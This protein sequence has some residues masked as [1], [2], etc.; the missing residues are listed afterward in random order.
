MSA[1]RIP[2]QEKL[3]EQCRA[4]QCPPPIY[5]EYSDRRGGRTAWSCSVHI[6]PHI[7]AKAT[8][9]YDG[10]YVEKAKDD[11]ALN[12]LQ[13]L[14][15]GAPQS[16]ALQGVFQQQKHQQAIQADPW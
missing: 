1:Q 9:W 11:A 4:L 8:Y 10:K 16:H 12:M 5:K 2:W 6:G 13:Q 15:K 3:Q 14:E 7:F